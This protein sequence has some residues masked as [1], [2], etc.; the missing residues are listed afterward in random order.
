MKKVI[1]LAP[2]PP[3][4]GGIASWTM[5]MLSASLKNNWQVG[6]VDEKVIGNRQIFG[7]SNP[8]RVFDEI[9]RCFK[10][11]QGL[12]NELKDESVKV[13]HS[14]IPSRTLSML[15]EYGCACIAKAQKRK[16]II[17]FRCTVPNTSKGRVCNFVLKL[18]S[19]K[20]D[21]IIVLNEQSYQYL[22][23]ITHT[24]IGLIPNFISAEEICDTKDINEDLKIVVYAGGV[25]ESKGA[26]DVLE[27]AKRFPDIEFRL[28]G[29]ADKDIK[30]TAAEIK[31]VTLT[32]QVEK[33]IV[34]N[35]LKNADVFVFMSYF[36][37]EGFSNSLVEAMAAGL[38][39]IVTDWAANKEM[40]GDA[41]GFVVGVKDVDSAEE[42]LKCLFDPDLRREQSKANIN[43]VKTCYT[44]EIIL[45]RYVDVYESL[46]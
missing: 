16:F 43:K 45:N 18:L 19:N 23:T 46:L 31:N 37:G 39:C 41:G 44:D 1:L 3:P 4:A 34:S 25:V 32:G 40:I 20:S 36:Y 26:C 33:N 30:N 7:S 2:T 14:C 28:V 17:H 38:P 6:V 12:M 13:V 9:K 22:K 8:R 24:P 35:E 5:R 11:W 10:I 29:N 42:A 27:L 21:Y 15:R